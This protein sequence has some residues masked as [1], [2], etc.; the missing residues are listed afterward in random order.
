MKR[1]LLATTLLVIA[2]FTAS[3]QGIPV[4]DNANIIQR[5]TQ[6]GQ[7]IQHWNSQR[8]GMQNQFNQLAGIYGAATGG[9]PMDALGQVLSA[10]GIYLPG[11]QS[12]DVMQALAGAS[13]YGNA[14]ET[15]Q[16]NLLALPVGTDPDAVEMGLRRSAL[17][18]RVEHALEAVRA[19]ETRLT[20][21]RDLRDRAGRTADIQESM[22]LQNRISAEQAS[23]MNDNDR[24]QQFA[25]LAA[26]QDRVEA[27]RDRE[28][29][30]QASQEWYDAT[31]HVWSVRW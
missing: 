16:R 19:A 29:G 24:T 27:M 21:L 1:T 20:G 31:K 12:G 25:A 8:V 6:F 13:H 17:A 10:A 2:P 26:A 11:L 18:N 28:A 30:R 23:L 9:R 4:Y 7:T 22:A 5:A 14:L 3:A 15:V